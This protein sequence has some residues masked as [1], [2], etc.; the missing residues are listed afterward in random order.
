MNAC[1]IVSL[2]LE[3]DVSGGDR[4]GVYI[5]GPKLPKAGFMAKDIE[6]AVEHFRQIGVIPQGTPNNTAM[7][8]QLV[9]NGY[10]F[11]IKHDP[12]NVE[13]I[14]NRVPVTT[15]PEGVE[16]VQMLMGLQ[17]ESVVAIRKHTKDSIKTEMFGQVLHGVEDVPQAQ[18]KAVV[19]PRTAAQAQPKTRTQP[20]QDFTP[21]TAPVSLGFTFDMG[22][23]EG[24]IIKE[25]HPAGPAAQAGL[26]AGDV[27]VQTSEFVTHEGETAGP[28]YVYNQKHLEY[29]LRKADPQYA[30][31]FRIVRGDREVWLP[32]LPEQKQPKQARVQP[33]PE[34]VKSPPAQ[35]AVARTVPNEPSPARQTGNQPPNVSSL[36]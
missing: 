36:T 12:G 19:Q 33:P 25:V 26:Q 35:S 31:P 7:V 16:Q 29:V 14:G 6:Q 8:D 34:R 13:V 5:F 4:T 15:T 23:K 21:I 24:V 27:I 20:D 18:T 3:A 9:N 11:I 1:E 28:Y 10:V 17:P 32:I 22:S 30:I 2:L